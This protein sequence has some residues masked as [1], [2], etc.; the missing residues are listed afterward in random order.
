MQPTI[1]NNY[2]L[3][4]DTLELIRKYYLQGYGMSTVARLMEQKHKRVVK[5]GQ[6]RQ[7]VLKWDLPRNSA[8]ATKCMANALPRTGR[9]AYLK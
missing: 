8:K 6:V 5:T 9:L 7:F 4:D 2:L 3:S 1:E